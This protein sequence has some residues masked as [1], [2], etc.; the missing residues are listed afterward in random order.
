MFQN[1]TVFKTAHA[2]AVHAGQKQ[3][4]VA[5]NVANADTPGYIARDITSFAE[6]YAPTSQ[7]AF[8]QRATRLNHIHG[9]AV[10]DVRALVEEDK[11]FAAPDGNSVSIET[12]MLRA[13]DAKR[14]HDRSLAIYKSTLTILR[15]SLGRQ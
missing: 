4:V 2:M 7:G 14:Q 9:S 8:S 11:T 12:E 13:T 5:Q 3:A 6:T 10:G 1:L 15:A